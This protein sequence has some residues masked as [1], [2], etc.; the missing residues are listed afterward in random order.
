MFCVVDMLFVMSV[1]QDVTAHQQD[2]TGH[3]NS[4][5]VYQKSPNL[6]EFLAPKCYQYWWF[7]STDISVTAAVITHKFRIE[8]GCFGVSIG[9][10]QQGIF[11]SKN[12]WRY[13]L[14]EWGL[15]IFPVL[16]CKGGI[17]PWVLYAISWSF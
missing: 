16:I 11:P 1:G 3:Q 8:P 7:S 4:Y 6:V 2:V 15:M 13:L 14:I 5:A 10:I 9:Q 17:G 12:K